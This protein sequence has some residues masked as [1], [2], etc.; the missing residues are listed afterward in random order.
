[1]R[2]LI[3]GGALLVLAACSSDCPVAPINPVN[4]V[5]KASSTWSCPLGNG[6]VIRTGA[7]APWEGC[8]IV[9]DQ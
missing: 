9:A 2:Y 3:F 1:M 6:V 4:S 5:K 7:T 8:E